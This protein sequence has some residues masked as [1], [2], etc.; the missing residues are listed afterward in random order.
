[1]TRTLDGVGQRNSGNDPRA[2]KKRLQQ[3]AN[4]L[5][6]PLTTSI[7]SP[8]VATDQLKIPEKASRE[9]EQA[10]SALSGHKLDDAEKHLRAAVR[11]YAKYSPAWVTLGQLLIRRARADEGKQACTQASQADPRYAPAYLCLADIA[12]RAHDWLEVLYLAG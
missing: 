7:A 6:P 8:T 12:A 1:M 3:D 10:C 11:E 4:C 2:P 9:Y 5:L